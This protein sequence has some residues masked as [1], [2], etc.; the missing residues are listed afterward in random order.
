[1]DGALAAMTPALCGTS[2]RQVLTAGLSLTALPSP[3]CVG[4]LWLPAAE[5]VGCGTGRA[6]PFAPGR[7]DARGDLAHVGGGMSGRRRGP[8]GDGDAAPGENSA[9]WL[10]PAAC[11]TGALA[12]EPTRPDGEGVAS[13]PSRSLSLSTTSFTCGAGSTPVQQCAAALPLFLP[14]WLGRQ[15]A[16]SFGRRTLVISA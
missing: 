6:W 3:L 10:T 7:G 5:V 11:E 2:C 4:K 14:K 9:E 12:R 8:D 13:A 16:A 15:T 1:M